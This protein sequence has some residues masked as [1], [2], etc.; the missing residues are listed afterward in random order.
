MS[1]DQLANRLLSEGSRISGDRIRR[2]DIPQRDF[3]RF[4]EVS[5][6]M[7]TLPIVIDDTPAITISAL[8]TRCR[9][10]KHTRGL[11]LVVV[12]YLPAH[13]PGGGHAA[14]KPGAGDL[15]DHAKG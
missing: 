6:E 13:A 7:A 15:D 5:R 8:R 14:G 1:A 11:E 3:D 10:L 9:R 2:G 12:D 4:V